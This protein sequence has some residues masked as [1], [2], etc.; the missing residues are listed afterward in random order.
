MRF[1]IGGTALRVIDIIAYLAILANGVLALTEADLVIDRFLV[2]APD[3]R[4]LWAGLLVFGGFVG[5]V[6]RITGRWLVEL[7]ATVAAIFGV[8]MFVVALLAGH[9]Q[10]DEP[11][12]TVLAMSIVAFAFMVRRWLELQLFASEPNCPNWRAKLT[13]MIARRT[14]ARQS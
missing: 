5:V 14:R 13:E 9:S 3:L 7:P 10:V 4:Y 6:G 2:D 1:R 12:F 8:L 11:F